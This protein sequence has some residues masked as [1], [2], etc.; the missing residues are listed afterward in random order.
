M[1]IRP[2]A[3]PKKILVIRFSSIGDI[4]LCSPVFRVLKKQLKAEIHWL[5]KSSYSF[6]NE[7]NPYIDHIHTI[8]DNIGK[9]L[10]RLKSE[11]YDLVVDLHKN[12][13]SWRFKR[14][15]G[16]PAL[17]FDK[18]NL[19]KWILVN[20]HLNWMKEPGH[21]V[22][23]YFEALQPL[24]IINDGEGLDYF[25]GPDIDN[26]VK[27]GPYIA[28]GIGGTYNTKKMPAEHIIRH[29]GEL[30]LP[31]V[32]LGSKTEENAAEIIKSHMGDRCINMVNRCDLHTTGKILDDAS[33]VISHDT[34]TMHIAAAFRKRILS[35]WGATA[36]ELGMYPYLPKKFEKHSVILEKENLSCHPCSKL[37]NDKCPKGHF[38]CLTA[39]DQEKVIK[40]INELL[41]E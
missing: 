6:V 5:T 35:V 18:R 10:Q 37:G 24:G 17:T 32:L 15:L 30:P 19:E 9:T 28:Y 16:I 14:S 36:P 2:P 13:R 39:L 40:K 25:Y 29:F 12:L 7:H 3:K 41:Q 22:D 38:K 4:I 27:I 23:R 20:F 1:S 21:L 8:K 11:D 31:L 34:A 33:Y 26:P